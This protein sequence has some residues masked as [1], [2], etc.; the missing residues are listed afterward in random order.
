MLVNQHGAWECASVRKEVEKIQLFCACDTR[1][2]KLQR[3]YTLAKVLRVCYRC[4]ECVID[5]ASVLSVLRVCYR[6]CECVI[7]VASV[8]SV[9][10]VS[11]QCCEFFLSKNRQFES[12][13]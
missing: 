12:A 9:L 2:V 1:R 3:L 8:F 10:R 7:G 13:Y 4:C 11:Y 5:V 6:C